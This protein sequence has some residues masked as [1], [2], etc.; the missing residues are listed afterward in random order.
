MR[1]KRIGDHQLPI[2]SRGSRGSV[3][4]DLS[5][6]GDHQIFPGQAVKIGTGFAWEID[7]ASAD[8]VPDIGIP[9]LEFGLIRDRSSG[10]DQ[11]R[12]V[13]AGVVDGDYRGEVKVTIRNHSEEPIHIMAGE[14]IAQM[15]ILVAA[16]YPLEEIEPDKELGKTARGDNGYGSTGK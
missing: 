2:P 4:W 5:S 7:P 9:T 16:V 11:G 10:P 1:I 8:E 15:I 12:V 13:E 3:G 14:R 6:V